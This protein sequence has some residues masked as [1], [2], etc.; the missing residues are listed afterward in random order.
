MFRALTII[1]LAATLSACPGGVM[2]AATKR[3][4]DGL[5]RGILNQ[6]DIPTVRDGLPAYLLILDGLIESQPDNTDLLIAGS[7]LYGAYASSFVD[8]PVRAK[9][10]SAR[11]HWYGTRMLCIEVENICDAL[12]DD[13]DKFTKLVS[14]IPEKDVAAIYSFATSWAAWVQAHSDD[15]NAIAQVPRIDSLMRRVVEL[16]EGHDYGNAWLYLGV[17]ATQLPPALGGKPEEGRTYFERAIALSDNRNL[18]AKVLFARQY[19]RLVFDRPLHDRLLREVLEAN[20]Q[21]DG[22]T[23]SNTLAQQQAVTLLESANDYF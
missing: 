20:P 11:A 4:A 3:V 7:K 17:L 10:L 18:Q 6:N 23:L 21:A 16:D 19:A 12:Q 1:T 9:R 8:D 14:K 22:L 5:S 13:F 2:D 15:W